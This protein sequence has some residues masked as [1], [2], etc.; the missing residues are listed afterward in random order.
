MDVPIPIL[1]MQKLNFRGTKKGHK[2]PVKWVLL[3]PSFYKW[4]DWGPEK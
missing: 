1:S 4:E 2:D 3:L